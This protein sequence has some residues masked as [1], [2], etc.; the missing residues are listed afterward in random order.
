MT[1]F[2]DRVDKILNASK[3]AFGESATL[4]PLSGGEYP[5]EGIFDNE[6]QAVDP[7]TEQVISGNHPVF[8]INLFDFDFEIK[9]KD[10]LKI[11]NLFYT[12][13]DVREDGQGGASLLIHRC[14]HEQ[15]VYK[16]KGA[17]TP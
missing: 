16:K 8:G 7:D 5:I 9:N 13:Y 6:Y 11:R 14:D 17:T 10:K 3:S 4:F 15:K 2:R 12:I 1:D